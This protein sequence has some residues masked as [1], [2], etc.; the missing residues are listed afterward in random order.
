ME[1]KLKRRYGYWVRLPGLGVPVVVFLLLLYPDKLPLGAWT[2]ALPIF[3]AS[4][5]G[6]TAALL[7]AAWWAIKNGKKALHKRLMVIC[8]GLGFFFIVSYGLF[9]LST[10][11]TRYG[12]ADRDGVVS[13]AEQEE[14]GV[15]RYVYFFVLISHIVLAVPVVFLVF[16]ALF[17]AY[18]E[19]F[20][21]HKKT[22]QYAFPAWLYVSV[23]GVLVYLMIAP[24]YPRP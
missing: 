4:I 18:H 20:G 10:A 23:T 12:D 13:L 5:N 15:G 14:A 21:Q 22:V 2:K 6:L 11:P 3:H 19:D 9:H 17:H 7:M 24:Y 1:E 16:K 8:V